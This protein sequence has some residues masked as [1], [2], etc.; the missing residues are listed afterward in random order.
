MIVQVDDAATAWRADFEAV[1]DIVLSRQLFLD[2]TDTV[3]DLSSFEM[4]SARS[5]CRDTPR[6]SASPIFCSARAMSAVGIRPGQPARS[7][8]LLVRAG[9]SWRRRLSCR[10]SRPTELVID[11]K[12]CFSEATFCAL[13]PAISR[14]WCPLP[15]FRKSSTDHRCSP[16]CQQTVSVPLSS[17][18]A[19]SG[20]SA[21]S[22]SG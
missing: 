6:S 17:S 16:F 15:S 11:V 2:A 19:T 22:S 5:V 1:D 12:S 14:L 9:V 13:R 21:W 3:F 18:S 8:P 7:C 20:S 4:D 10:G